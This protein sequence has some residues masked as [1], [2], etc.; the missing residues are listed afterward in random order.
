MSRII[1]SIFFCRQILGINQ[2]DFCKSSQVLQKA[3]VENPQKLGLIDPF[4]V[5][6][7]RGIIEV[8]QGHS[9]AEWEIT[10]IQEGFPEMGKCQDLPRA[11]QDRVAWVL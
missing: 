3:V 6:W 1:S 4:S 7:F 5:R 11:G 9:T 10:A 8:M 2:I